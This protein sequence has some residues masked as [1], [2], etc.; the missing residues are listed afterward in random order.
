MK[1]R[2]AFIC[3]LTLLAPRALHAQDPPPPM[4]SADSIASDWEAQFPDAESRRDFRRLR[5]YRT[6]KQTAAVHEHSSQRQL[7]SIV[8]QVEADRQARISLRVMLN[9][10]LKIEPDSAGNVKIDATYPFEFDNL[11]GIPTPGVIPLADLS[12]ARL[13][14]AQQDSAAGQTRAETDSVSRVIAASIHTLEQDIRSAESTIDNALAPEYQ[15]QKFRTLVSAFFALLIGVMIVA[16]FGT[17]YK[18]AGDSVGSLLLSDGGLQFV[19][20]FVLIIAI[21]LFG[22]LNILEGR[23]LAAILSGIAG[24]ILG[25]GAQVKTQASAGDA[26]PPQPAAPASDV[27]AA[28]SST[29]RVPSIFIPPPDAAPAAA[30]RAPMGETTAEDEASA[31]RPEPSAVG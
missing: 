22:I 16:F 27:P 17:I 28:G 2:Y 15:S 14:L 3:V 11:I 23:E 19:T 9:E 31:D 6:G 30:E 8:Q 18:K 1:K 10:V 12:N 7:E 29:V 26:P 20:I 5:E 25:R 4:P 21:I 13:R 24:Y